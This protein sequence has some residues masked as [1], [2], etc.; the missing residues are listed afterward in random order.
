M[1]NPR[2]ITDFG[3]QAVI[4]PFAAA[5]ALIF[6][7]SGWHRGALA[8]TVA[9]GATLG[10]MLLLKLGFLACGHLIPD[11]RLT[12]PSGHT[13]AAVVVYGGL[14]GIAMRAVTNNK[15]WLL[16]CT[17]AVAILCAIVFGATRLRLGVHSMPEVL[18][19]GMIGVGGALSSTVLAGVPSP[20]VRLSHVLVAGLA[21]LTL[22]HGIH[23]PAEAAIRAAA[24]TFWPFSTCR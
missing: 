22:M 11:V 10:L 15:Y 14:A 18:A 24:F 2:F 7:V 20:A 6:L 8:W 3:D 23:L 21:I 19:G 16:A 17:L 1:F 5:I 4:L 13:A 9:V 12:S